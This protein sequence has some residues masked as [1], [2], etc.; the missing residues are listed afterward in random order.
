M[1]ARRE[2]IAIY[3]ET[4][5]LIR[6]RGERYNNTLK[7]YLREK[8]RGMPIGVVVGPGTAALKFI[9]FARAEI[10]PETPAI[11]V[12]NP[13]AAAEAAILPGVTGLVRRQPLQA[14]VSTAQAVMPSLKYIA[15]VGDAPRQ[16]Y[17]RARLKEQSAY[18]ADPEI[19]DLTGLRMAELLRRI[20]A[21]PNHTVIYFTTL[22]FDGDL[23][24][25][26][27]RDALAAIAEVANRPI[28]V[29]LETHVGYGSVGGMVADPSVIGNALARL[30][31]RILDGE[32]ASSIPVVDGDFVRPIFDARQLQR[33]GISER[34]L[35]EES[36]IRF[37]QPTA[38][39]QYHRQILLAAA[40]LLL[41]SLLIVWLVLE[42]R[43]RRFAELEE[44]RHMGELA[45]MNRRAAIGEMSASIAHE[46]KQP[47]TA[48]LTNSGVGLRWLSKQTPNVTEA[49]AALERIADDVHHAN[50]VIESVRTMFKHDD[51]SR[52]LIDVNDVIREVLALLRIEMK[53]HD[54][55]VHA[56]LSATA[57]RIRADRT[58]LQQVILN[59]VRNAI[60]AMG[61][62][63]SRPRVLK[64]E[65]AATE[66]GELIV[67]I[68]DNGPGIEPDVLARLFEPFVT[69]KSTGMGMGLSICR[70]IV[71]AHG[72]RLSTAPAS[73][74]G[75]V[76]EIV[77]P[78]S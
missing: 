27:S 25:Y 32:S 3:A 10:W 60:E 22:T 11:F 67:T 18:V 70:S 53:E 57:P 24:S 61:A 44:R 51:Q 69:T 28:I 8:Y 77:L 42:H 47:L 71:E 66:S 34:S 40:A 9:L 52:D 21:L 64:V 50:K 63:N 15:L 74:H 46:I 14:T 31:L 29:D 20:A 2:H 48:I 5:D 56:V 17:Q 73:P 13:A 68:E 37:R 65:S 49:V 55:W 58:Q 23:P 54:V 7:T 36:E 38:W 72:G 26:V 43:R 19:I 6:Y 30:A 41:Q 12:S 1:S 78:M 59:L 35:P 45:L 62:V 75:T 76:F 4:L 16:E 39:E 33:W